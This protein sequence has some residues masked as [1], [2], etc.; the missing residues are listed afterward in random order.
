[1]APQWLTITQHG[2]EIPGFRP[3]APRIRPRI[4]HRIRPRIRH[5]GGGLAHMQAGQSLLEI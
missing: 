3:A 4:K 5:F 2:P 1:M